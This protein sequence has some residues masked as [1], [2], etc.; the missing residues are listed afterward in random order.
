VEQVAHPSESKEVGVFYRL[1]M[2]ACLGFIPVAF[3]QTIQTKVAVK[4]P[5]LL[6]LELAGLSANRATFPLLAST[7]HDAYSLSEQSSKLRIFALGEWQLLASIEATPVAVNVQARL[8][9]LPRPLQLST[10]AKTILTGPS[11]Q[12]THLNAL[13][14][15]L[16]PKG[17]YPLIIVYTLIDP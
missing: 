17:A 1:L 9:G 4:L 16:P 8:Y 13:T 7:A 5:S 12:E 11:T 2:L 3:S 14:Q 6:K 15:P 10:F